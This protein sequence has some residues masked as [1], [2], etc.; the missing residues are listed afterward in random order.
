MRN[1]T[2]S[3]L[4][5][6]HLGVYRHQ[7]ETTGGE[8]SGSRVEGVTWRNSNN[9]LVCLRNLRLQL[10]KLL[11]IVSDAVIAALFLH[12]KHRAEVSTITPMLAVFR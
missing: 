3:A 6:G 7:R 2:K 10:V 5:E 8:K 12:V 9:R 1:E 4:I 11:K